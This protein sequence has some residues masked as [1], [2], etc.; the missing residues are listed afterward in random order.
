MSWVKGTHVVAIRRPGK[1][2]I[3]YVYAWRGGPQI[4]TF[5][6]EKRPKPDLRHLQAIVAARASESIPAPGTLLNVCRELRSLDPDNR[7]H[8]PEWAALAA[9]TRRTWGYQLDAIE[10]KWGKTP[11]AAWSSYKM[12]PFVVEWRD[13]RKTTPRTADLGVQVLRYVLEFARLRGHVRL[14]VAKDI[15]TLYRG[16]DRAEIVWTEI[17]IDTFIAK[18]IELERPQMADGLRL[19]ALTGLRRADLVSL[20]WDQVNEFAI[21]KKALKRSAR[22]RRFATMPRIPELDALLT[23][24]KAR[25]RSEGVQTVLVNSRGEP[26]SG[27]GFGGSFNRIRDEAGIVHI[28]SE[29]GEAK[30]KHLHDVRGTFATKLCLTTNLTDKEIGDVMAWT[31]ERVGNIRRVYVD[32]SSIVVAIGKRITNGSVKGTVKRSVGERLK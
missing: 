15:P 30:K 9:G 19:A 8:S 32:Q 1:A 26:W 3:W 20:T 17:D 18:A 4:D 31:P 27:D 21:V 5:V 16:G 6:G 13:S 7:P 25:P 2:T 12:V 10:N 14:N 28:D 24:L 11:I 29:T 23:E 22:K